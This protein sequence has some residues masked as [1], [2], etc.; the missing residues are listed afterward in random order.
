MCGPECRVQAG[1]SWWT[2]HHLICKTPNW[3]LSL[4][5]R[6]K[7]SS[8]HIRWTKGAR[9]A[10]GP[11]AEGL[12]MRVRKENLRQSLF[13][14]SLGL[15]L[16]YYMRIESPDMYMSSVGLAGEQGQKIGR[17][18]KLTERPAMSAVNT[19]SIWF[20]QYLV[21][22]PLSNQICSIWYS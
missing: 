3:D 6:T 7:H 20:N 18:C 22:Q 1:I 5:S 2:D 8:L 16:V 9:K 10:S 14:P 19:V 11:R 13:R 12:C 4:S 21:Q 17:V 15:V